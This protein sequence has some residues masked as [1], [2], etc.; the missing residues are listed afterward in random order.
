MRLIVYDVEVLAFDW[1]VVFKDV[2]TGTHTVIHNDK[3]G[4]AS[5]RERV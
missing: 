4:R 3:I 1:I 2:E 5:C